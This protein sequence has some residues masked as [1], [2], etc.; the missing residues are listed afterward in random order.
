MKAAAL[1][2]GPKSEWPQD[3]KKQLQK[4]DIVFGVDRGALLLQEL[5]I[6]TDVAI[7]DFD[8]LKKPELQKLEQQVSD[9]RYSNPIK[10]LTDSELMLQV[11]LKDYQVDELTVFGATGGRIDHFLT[12][13]LMILNPK[14]TKF[15]SKISLIDKQNYVKFYSSGNFYIE[16]KKLYPYFGVMNLTEVQDLN[17]QGARYNLVNYNGKYPRVFSSNEFLPNENKFNLSFKKGIVAIIWSKD[18]NRFY[19]I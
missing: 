7:G 9:I 4:F 8:S 17:I 13:L 12:N 15:V 5:G 14:I 6:K 11:A 19:N 16:E 10:D 2:G 18:I 3:I 1:L